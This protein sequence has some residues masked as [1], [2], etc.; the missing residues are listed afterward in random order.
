MKTLAMAL[1]AFYLGGCCDFPYK[2]DLTFYPQPYL[3]VAMPAEDKWQPIGESMALAFAERRIYLLPQTDRQFVRVKIINPHQRAL[4][5]DIGQFNTTIRS[6]PATAPV[7]ELPPVETDAA[8][9]QILCDFYA[10]RLI[11][12]PPKMAMDFFVEVRPET[13]LSPPSA[14]DQVTLSGRV[15]LTDGALVEPLVVDRARVPLD[16][17]QRRPLV[18][19]GHLLVQEGQTTLLVP[20]T[21]PSEYLPVNSSM[22]E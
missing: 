14:G 9:R 16:Q 15:W 6:V 12:I 2:V 17:L 7:Q 21:G 10:D 22:S 8:K 18:P 13:T 3:G 5:V 19:M 4:A 1:T 11:A 20:A